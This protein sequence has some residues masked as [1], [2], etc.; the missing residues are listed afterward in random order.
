MMIG[1]AANTS[2]LPDLNQQIQ[3]R[4]NL[5]MPATSYRLP[6]LWLS[7]FQTAFQTGARVAGR[8]NRASSFPSPTRYILAT[9]KSASD[10]LRANIR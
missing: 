7:S 1:A 3:T 6:P 2:L 10:Y 9:A 5:T 4:A 8:A